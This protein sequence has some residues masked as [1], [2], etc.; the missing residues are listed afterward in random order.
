MKMKLSLDAILC[1]LTVMN[2]GFLKKLCVFKRVLS[3]TYNV[4]EI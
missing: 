2:L 3:L 4:A 1:S